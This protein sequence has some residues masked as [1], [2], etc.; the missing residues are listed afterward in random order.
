MK[1][2]SMEPQPQAQLVSQIGTSS[3]R[4]PIRIVISTGWTLP[5]AFPPTLTS[6]W[7]FGWWVRNDAHFP[8]AL[9]WVSADLSFSFGADPKIRCSTDIVV[10][11]FL[12]SLLDANRRSAIP[13]FFSFPVGVSQN[14]RHE[15]K[16]NHYHN[17]IPYFRSRYFLKKMFVCF[18]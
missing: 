12:R 8:I 11:P 17:G 14:R 7:R 1:P 2:Q 6:S 16:G 4:D 15:I 18:L 5:S 3:Q 13:P 9:T 10:V